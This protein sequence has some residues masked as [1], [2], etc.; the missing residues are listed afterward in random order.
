MEEKAT[1]EA[2]R[3]AAWLWMVVVAQDE[4]QEALTGHLHHPP[5]LTA[6]QEAAVLRWLQL[7]SRHYVARRAVAGSVLLLW[8]CGLK[9]CAG[10]QNARCC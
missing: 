10:A 1:L 3:Q 9:K 7:I 2:W 5:W 6:E 4:S 8:R